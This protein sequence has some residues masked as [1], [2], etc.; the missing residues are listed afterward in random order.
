MKAGEIHS[1]GQ[2]IFVKH[3]ALFWTL[4]IGQQNKAVKAPS[5]LD[6]VWGN[7][8]E[9]NKFK[10]HVREIVKHYGKKTSKKSRCFLERFHNGRK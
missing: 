8:Q 3:Q 9:T 5:L 2:S 6:L 1:F 7:R 10:N 4:E